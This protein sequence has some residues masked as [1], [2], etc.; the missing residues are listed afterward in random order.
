[1]IKKINKNTEF[2]HFEQLSKEWWRENGKFKILHTINPLRIKYIKKNIAHKKALKFTNPFKNLEILDL[3][4]GGGLICEPLARLEAK[5]TGIDFINDNIKAAKIHANKSNL[6]IRYLLQ[7]LNSINLKKKY[8]LILML[9]VIEHLDNW[10]VLIR[11]SIKN[12][13]P[14]GKLIISTIN[15]NILSKIFAIYI[16]E[17]ILNIIPQNT[18][19]YDKLIKPRELEDVLNKNKM[20]VTDITGLFFNPITRD[21]LLSKNKTRINYFCTA[22]KIN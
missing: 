14:N 4:C 18:H 11:N 1:M 12:L 22:E 9:E 8:D 2:L 16:S 20:K 19:K 6:N 5:V 21:W 17:R 15:R 10:D 13:K 3:G 7:D